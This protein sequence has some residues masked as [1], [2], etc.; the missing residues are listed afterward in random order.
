MNA[1]LRITLF[2]TFD[3]QGPEPATRLAAQPKLVSV[4]VYLLLATPRGYQRRD[5]VA[6]LF[7]PEQ[8]DPRARASLRNVLYGLRE[9]LGPDAVETRGDEEVRVPDGAVECDA[10]AFERAIADGELARALELYR[11][12]LLAGTFLGVPALEQWLEERRTAYRSAAADAAWTL[13]QRYETATDL[14]AAT[15]WARKAA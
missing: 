15:R 7:W 3:I 4:L 14:T 9:A 1:P 11:G 13:A 2:G 10:L 12:E 5:R 6:G 8:P